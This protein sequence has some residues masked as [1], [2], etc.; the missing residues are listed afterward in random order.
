MVW[1]MR[2]PSDCR[3]IDSS[4]RQTGQSGRSMHLS[5]D[6]AFSQVHMHSARKTW[7]KASNRPHDIDAFEVVRSVFFEDRCVFYSV[8]VRT[9]SSVF[10]SY[11]P[12]PG[13]HSLTLHDALPTRPHA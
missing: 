6:L 4:L 13:I 12:T 9:R 7:V 3:V 1:I 10:T 2:L 11:V 8:F 5:N